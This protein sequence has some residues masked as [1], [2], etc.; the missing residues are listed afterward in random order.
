M[1]GCILPAFSKRC[2]RLSFF[3]TRLFCSAVFCWVVLFCLRSVHADD[4]HYQDYVVGGR[5]AVLGGAFTSISD[6]PSGLYY[7]PAGIT[8]VK[9]SNLQVNAGLYGFERGSM[10]NQ[11]GLPVPGVEKLTV[12]F[13]DL[14]VIPASAG[15]VN[16]FGEKGNDGL[17]KQAFGVSV[18]V[19]SFR[20]YSALAGQDNALYKRRVTDRELWSGVGYARKFGKLRLGVASY[21]ILR[22]V[23]DIEDVTIQE[24]LEEAG[25]DRFESVVN[26]IS[27]TN[28]NMVFIAGAKY[29]L[30]KN[31]LLGISLRSPSLQVH[32]QANLR[33]TRSRSDPTAETGSISSL[34]R[35]LIQ[36]VPSETC[37]APMLRLGASYQQRYHYTLS[38]DVNFYAPISYTLVDVDKTYRARLP[39]NPRI[40]RR[41]V[42]NVNMGGEYLIIRQ[43]SIGM[44]LFTDFS[45]APKIA[46]QPK[47]DQP[48]RVDLLGL[49]MAIGHYGEHSLSRLGVVYS[50][51]KGKDIIPASDIGRL[52]RSEQ[53]FQKVRYSQTFFYIFLSS[54]FRY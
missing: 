40:E 35:L 38:F 9:N 29:F 31:I 15:F 51:G 20:S 33:F 7:N 11:L 43:V 48:P 13:T 26:D 5:A 37:Y 17:P 22:S 14:I 52:L 27:L 25:G 44:G 47:A 49:T 10:G 3:H 8:D 42:V 54:T 2:F 19:P 32:S 46:E 21:Y 18:V 12:E 16:T 36:D 30:T 34:E 6:D 53:T 1:T 4:T 23:V 45:S 50:F 24:S 39:F 41:G 28:G